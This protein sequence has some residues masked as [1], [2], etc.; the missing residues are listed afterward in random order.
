MT[1]LHAWP[2]PLIL[3][4]VVVFLGCTPP[5]AT[6]PAP[7]VTDAVAAPIPS[8][9]PPPGPWTVAP[10]ASDLPGVVILATGGTIA[11]EQ[12]SS[13][14]AGYKAGQLPVDALVDAVPKLR[15]KARMRGEQIAQIGS[16]DMNDAVWLKLQR[17]LTEQCR[18]CP[19]DRIVITHG[20]DTIEETAYFLSL[21]VDAKKPI[22]LTAAM[23]PSTAISA[24]GP[25]NLYNSVVLAGSPRAA[26]YGVVVCA[27][28]KVHGPRDVTKSNTT[29]VETFRSPN[30]GPVAT[31]AYGTTRF[32]RAPTTP[33]DGLPIDVGQQA[34]L[35]AVAIV[36]SH[37]NMGPELIDA[38]VTSG[39][40]GIVLAGVGNGNTSAD[41]LDALARAA[42]TGVVVVRA[43]RAGSGFADRNVEVDDDAL[44]FV[45]AGW[46]SAAKARVLLQVALTKTQ[47]VATIQQLFF[48]DF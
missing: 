1:R 24:D 12:A 4:L 16:Q 9:S 18:K 27:N 36:F 47:D 41:A 10:S 44:G 39:A 37:T 34:A 15:E 8:S 28:D 33:F 48:R 6:H 26:R 13:D 2:W 29:D 30:R 19:T 20:T 23:R 3:S 45:A 11:G 14:D 22:V 32:L 46:H 7:S 21:T 43:S 17:R 35:P 31:I 42:K 38:A 25:L 40:K 5:T